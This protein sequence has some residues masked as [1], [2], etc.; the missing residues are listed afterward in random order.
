MKT[1]VLR[2]RLRLDR[3]SMLDALGLLVFALALA[4][5]AL[6]PLA[7]R[8]AR[9]RHTALERAE[10][11]QAARAERLRQA[12]APTAQDERLQRFLAVRGESGYAEQSVKTLFAVAQAA[13]LAL[14]Q[15][16]YESAVQ[17]GSQEV[18]RIALPVRGSYESIRR[19][20]EDSLQAMPFAALDQVEFKRER[21]DDAQL[22][23]RLRFTLF[24]GTP[25]ATAGAGKP[26][27]L[28]VLVER[29]RLIGS[30][31]AASPSSAPG[32]ALFASHSWA[33]PP[34]PPPPAAPVVVPKPTAPPLP[35]S[36]V[37]K[38][39]EDGQWRV[40]LA[41]TDASTLVVKEQDVIDET[42]RVES[43]APPLLKL[44][45]LPLS[46]VQ[47]LSIE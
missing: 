12:T 11:R 45:Y 18:Y 25:A 46:E 22:E 3:C 26:A 20:C 34:P 10:A 13:G 8:Q 31:P 16:A 43:V 2:W 5:W 30:Q 4:G 47:T 32:P 7:H 39:E 17:P 38:Q 6:L 9:D 21:V 36:Y 40:F 23:A 44:I 41:R 28:P 19:F 15:A 1:L 35:F 14:D 27:D 29:S 37:G 24:L 42:Y 33:P